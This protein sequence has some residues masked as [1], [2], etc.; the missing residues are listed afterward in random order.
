MKEG[1]FCFQFVFRFRRPENL[2]IRRGMTDLEGTMLFY[3][4][5]KE[6][7]GVCCNVGKISMF[8]FLGD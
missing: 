7:R 1:K 8:G 5:N 3:L 6:R 4:L 2:H